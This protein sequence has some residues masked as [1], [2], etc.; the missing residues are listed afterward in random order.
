MR[1]SCSRQVMHDYMSFHTPP[2]CFQYPLCYKTFQKLEMTCS[3]KKPQVSASALSQMQT[4]T[5]HRAARQELMA[6]FPL[7]YSTTAT[8]T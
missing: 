3:S 4:H 7:V 2:S 8:A 6:V 1:V 5:F